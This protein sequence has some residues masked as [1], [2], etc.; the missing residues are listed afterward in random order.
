MV[1]IKRIGIKQTA[2]FFAVYYFLMSLIFIL[3]IFLI[4]L[5]IGSISSTNTSPVPGIFGGVFLIFVP[6]FYAVIGYTMVACGSWFYNVIAKK[7]GGVEFEFDQ[8]SNLELPK[9]N[10][11]VEDI[12]GTVPETGVKSTTV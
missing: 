6:I 8:E 9:E 12:K 10:R 1:Q 3:P 4:T 7:I 11:A 5:L 2:K